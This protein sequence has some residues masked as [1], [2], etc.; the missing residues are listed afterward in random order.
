MKISEIYTT[1]PQGRG[2]NK[3][4]KEE[5]S[6][7]T[8]FN[9]EDKNDFQYVGKRGQL[10]VWHDSEYPGIFVAFA[11]DEWAMAVTTQKTKFGRQ[12]STTTSNPKYRGFKMAQFVYKL[13]AKKT[14]SLSSDSILAPV[15]NA[16]WQSFEDD[17]QV[18][19]EVVD[20]NTGKSR[21]YE[22]NLDDIKTFVYRIIPK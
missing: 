9:P 7:R 20:K 10:S 15:A 3:W 13:I 16:L 18:E 17:S 14:G 2:F 6:D 1:A 5:Y 22:G 19:L 21:P 12:I 4:D 11:G 8:P